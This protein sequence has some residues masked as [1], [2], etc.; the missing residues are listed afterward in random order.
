MRRFVQKQEEKSRPKRHSNILNGMQ[1]K[2]VNPYFE[3]DP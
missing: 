3:L 2:K 1:R